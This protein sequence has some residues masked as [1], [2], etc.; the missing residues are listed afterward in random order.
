MII[1]GTLSYMPQIT[2]A[3]NKQLGRKGERERKRQNGSK[4]EGTRD[5]MGGSEEEK[6]ARFYFATFATFHRKIESERKNSGMERGKRGRMGGKENG[7]EIRK[8]FVQVSPATSHE[9]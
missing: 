5:G 7:R 2:Q 4:W 9:G 3:A 8:K 6:R 1:T